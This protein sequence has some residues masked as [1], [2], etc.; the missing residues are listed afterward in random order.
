MGVATVVA[1]PTAPPLLLLC[2][3]PS[4]LAAAASTVVH[5]HVLYC[6]TAGYVLVQLLEIVTTALT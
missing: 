6:A 2:I 4:P 5:V 1:P 3:T